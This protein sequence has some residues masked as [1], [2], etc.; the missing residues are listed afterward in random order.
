M[1]SILSDRLAGWIIAGKPYWLPQRFSGRLRPPAVAK[2]LQQVGG[3]AN[4]LPLGA[5][6]LKAAQ[7]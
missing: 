3:S 2:Q 5:H 4:Q 6:H 7:A 1:V